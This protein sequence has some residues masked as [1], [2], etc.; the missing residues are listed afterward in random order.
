M[1]TMSSSPLQYSNWSL[2]TTWY[3]KNGRKNT[4]LVWKKKTYP[5]TQLYRS[6]SM[7]PR[8]FLFISL[9]D[10]RDSYDKNSYK[11]TLKHRWNWQLPAFDELL[12]THTC[13]G[14]S[15]YN[16]PWKTARACFKTELHR[17]W[18]FELCSVCRWHLWNFFK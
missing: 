3:L 13:K 15:W 2:N 16:L 14:S 5:E 8:S 18:E 9:F 6:L 1:S 7:T 17:T 12:T 10:P 4:R 11:K